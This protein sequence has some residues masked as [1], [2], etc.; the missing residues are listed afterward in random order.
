MIIFLSWSKEQS[1][2]YAELF[3]KFFPHWIQTSQPW[4]SETDINKGVLSFT[5]ILKNIEQADIGVIFITKENMDEPWLNYESAL[6]ASK[7][8]KICPVLIDIDFSDVKGPLKQYQGTKI[9]K[10]DL[11]KLIFTILTAVKE[12]GH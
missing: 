10:E 9:E 4:F 11:K 8:K 6:L 3:K 5:D 1:K 12:H 7:E 2:K